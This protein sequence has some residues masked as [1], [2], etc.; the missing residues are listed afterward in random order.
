MG[1]PTPFPEPDSPELRRFA[2]RSQ[3]E[4]V[5]L[6]RYL[7]EA[8]VPLN[9]FVG[10]G[11]PFGVVTLQDIDEEVGK[12]IF[13]GT[14]DTGLRRQLLNS[15]LATFVGFDDAGKVQFAA[16]LAAAGT[17]HAN[18]FTA[19]IPAQLLRLQ[20]RSAA[21]M[22]LERARAAVCRIPVPGAAG[23][24][25]ALRVLDI[26]TGGIAV[27]TYP[28]RFELTVG[29]EID[30]CQLDLAGIG[31][32]AVSLRVRHLG[33]KRRDSAASCCGC[34]FVRIRPDIQALLARHILGRGG[35]DEDDQLTSLATAPRSSAAKKNRA[36]PG[37]FSFAVS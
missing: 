9:A 14:T 13:K 30:G 20:R 26:S 19:P 1:F 28:E 24:W 11:E 22:R 21:R 23:E 35:H 37:S 8:D 15:P 7:R 10:A 3:N 34:E 31:G 12:L 4:I 2:V 27:L 32:V 25:E 5:N 33:P 6:L 16:P 36:W 18:E 29:A 17:S